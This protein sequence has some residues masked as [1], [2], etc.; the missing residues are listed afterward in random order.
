[1]TNTKHPSKKKRDGRE[2]W[3][4]WWQRH[5]SGSGQGHFLIDLKIKN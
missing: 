4:A 5:G 3:Q 2:A 1:M